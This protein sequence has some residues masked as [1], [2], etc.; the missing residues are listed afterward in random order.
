VLLYNPKL[1]ASRCKPGRFFAVPSRVDSLEVKVL[2]VAAL[3]AE[4]AT[5]TTSSKQQ[6]E[7]NTSRLRNNGTGQL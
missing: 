2:S 6:L 1:K 3:C 5:R 7:R 4:L